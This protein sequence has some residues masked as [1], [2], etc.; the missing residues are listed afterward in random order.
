MLSPIA[1]GYGG[2]SGLPQA[3]ESESP[4][5]PAGDGV[6]GFGGNAAPGYTLPKDEG[7]KVYAAFRGGFGI[8]GFG[9]DGAPAEAPVKGATNIQSANSG[10]G[11]FGRGGSLYLNDVLPG[12]GVVG[13]ATDP[14]AQVLGGD[15]PSPILPPRIKRS[16]RD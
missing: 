6:T 13:F 12:S 16:W 15:W 7:Q 14:T 3:L 11:V 4:N 2:D 8:K 1:T 9:G 10:V 5:V